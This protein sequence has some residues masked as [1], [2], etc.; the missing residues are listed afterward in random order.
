MLGVQ[1]DDLIIGTKR[2]CKK[3]N[4]LNYIVQSAIVYL[5]EKVY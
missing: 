1:L 5:I 3:I 4:F 2:K